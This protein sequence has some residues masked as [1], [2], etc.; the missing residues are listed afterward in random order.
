MVQCVSCLVAAA[1][2]ELKGALFEYARWDGGFGRFGVSLSMDRNVLVVGNSHGGRNESGTAAVFRRGIAGWKRVG[3]ISARAGGRRDHFGAAVGVSGDII[4]VGAPREDSN[5]T[6][7][8]GEDGNDDAHDSGA[9]YVFVRDADDWRQQAYLKAPNTDVWDSFG[10]SVAVDE[11]TIVV[12]AYRDDRG[13]LSP[14][15]PVDDPDDVGAAH[16]FRTAGGRWF[17]AAYLKPPSTVGVLWFGYSVAISEDLIVVGAPHAGGSSGGAAFVYRLRSDGWR[18]EAILSGTGVKD[19][20][21]FGTAVAISNRKIVVGAPGHDGSGAAFIYSRSGS[22]WSEDIELHAANSEFGDSFG[23]SVGIS[24]EVAVVGARREKSASTGING[25]GVDDSQ[26]DAGAAY[27]FVD[28]AYGWKQHAYVKASDAGYEDEFGS[29]V[30]VSNNAFAI[31]APGSADAVYIYGGRSR[32]LRPITTMTPGAQGMEIVIPKVFGRYVGIEYSKDL[33]AGSWIELGNFAP[34]NE[35][36]VF[37]DPD[38]VR[39][40]RS[41]G[42]YRAFLRPE[43]TEITKTPGH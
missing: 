31:G 23:C 40:S 41:A 9:A 43:L 20:D 32:V 28:G 30:T 39:L 11:T 18:F 34:V 6:E 22:A 3:G 38:R 7:I 33:S 42:Y 12:G 10:G 17:H 5:S 16:V 13:F 36:M 2:D 24:G 14:K 29:A 27:L 4:V 21:A 26:F 15:N 25:N 8:N 19:G 37:I 1:G 35:Q